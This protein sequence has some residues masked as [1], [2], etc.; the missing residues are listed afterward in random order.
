[1]TPTPSPSR[2]RSIDSAPLKA[3]ADGR[4]PTV[5]TLRNV[6][7][8]GLKVMDLGATILA[9]E[10]PDRTGRL[11][12]VVLGF[13]SAAEYLAHDAYFGPLRP[14]RQSDRR[15]PVYARWTQLPLGAQRPAEHAAR[16]RHWLQQ[17]HV[18]WR[19]RQ[20]RRR[21]RHPIHARERG[22]RRGLSRRCEGQRHLCVDRNQR[23]DRD[24]HRRDNRCGDA[25]QYFSAHLLEFAGVKGGSVLDHNCASR[26]TPTRPLIAH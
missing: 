14:L 18:A 8:A 5:W 24:L 20:H 16:R 4:T 21:P 15:R 6:S 19:G 22:W 9:L 7:G 1:M 13:D 12:D 26:P 23:A 25:V 3:L 10:V 17:T 11:A 2:H